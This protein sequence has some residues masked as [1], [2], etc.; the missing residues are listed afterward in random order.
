[1]PAKKLNAKELGIPAFE[2]PSP[3][4]GEVFALTSHARAR[5]A[6]EFGL[7]VK[8]PGFNI[9]VLGA[10]RRR[11]HDGQPRLPDQGRGR[12]ADAAGLDLP[13]QLPALHRPVPSPCRPA[14][15]G[16]SRPA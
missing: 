14:R 1:M 11:A 4:A 8:A 6:L 12:L 15:A 16:A 3:A 13:E 2:V 10:D 7:S 9:F 5:E